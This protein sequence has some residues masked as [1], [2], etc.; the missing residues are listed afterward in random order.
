M[1]RQPVIEL[2]IGTEPDRARALLLELHRTL[3]N[4]SGSGRPGAETLNAWREWSARASA[5]AHW[6]FT[7]R[8]VREVILGPQFAMLQSLAVTDYGP[9]LS[10]LIGAEIGNRLGELDR[11]ARQ[12]DDAQNAWG[13]ASLVIVLDTG[14]LLNA[15]PRIAKVV[16]D[17]LLNAIT[18][19]AAFVIP[20]QVV[21]ELDQ[22]KM[23]R[24]GELRTN[25]AFALKWLGQLV[26]AGNTPTPFP[27]KDSS[28]TL[29]VWVDENDRVPLAEVDRD[30]IDRVLQ[31]KPFT[32]RIVIASMDQSMVFRARAYGLE[33]VLVTQDH[34]PPRRDVALSG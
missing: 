12:I 13:R 27:S 32:S 30:I 28:S 18:R 26:D 14:L 10:M 33:S 19:T 21:E 31:I 2:R 5:L 20:I 16:W 25:A 17:D 15:G 23:N 29:R 3:E 34:I 7:E 11:A 6:Q 4:I 24:N 8:T 9:G 22:Q 1:Y